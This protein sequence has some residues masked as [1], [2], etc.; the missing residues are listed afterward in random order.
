MVLWIKIKI[1]NFM[2]YDLIHKAKS[3]AVLWIKFYK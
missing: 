2:D 3:I 1:H